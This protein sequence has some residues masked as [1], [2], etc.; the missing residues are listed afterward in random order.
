MSNPML[1]APTEAQWQGA[2]DEAIAAWTRARAHGPE[3]FRRARH[4]AQDGYPSQSMGGAMGHGVSD[5]VGTLAVADPMRDEVGKAVSEFLA[6]ASESRGAMREMMSRLEFVMA[7]RADEPG[8]KNT[9]PACLGCEG[10]AVPRPRR[11]MCERCYH[12]WVRRGC[13]ELETFRAELRRLTI[14]GDHNADG[15]ALTCGNA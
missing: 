12:R 11:G 15:D 4:P 1:H 8:R 7:I 9:V 13:P 10:P 5:P 6:L 14:V 3:L 2:C